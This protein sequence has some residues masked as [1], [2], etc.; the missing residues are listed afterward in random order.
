ML[1][2]VSS[3]PDIFIFRKKTWTI[4]HWFENAAS[5]NAP[6]TSQVL[7]NK[8]KLNTLTNV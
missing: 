3:A 1:Y 5:E 6:E 8:I 2:P 7:S 4:H